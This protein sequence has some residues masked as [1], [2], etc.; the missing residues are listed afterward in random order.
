MTP[1]SRPGERVQ[2]WY[3]SDCQ[4]EHTASVLGGPIV[5]PLESPPLQS[6]WEVESERGEQEDYERG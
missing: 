4:C 5:P 2:T 3:C 6:P 1:E